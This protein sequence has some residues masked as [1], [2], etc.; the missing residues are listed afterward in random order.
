MPIYAN[1]INI[2]GTISGLPLYTNTLSAS[3]LSNITIQDDVRING[4]VY[5]N[6]RMDVGSTVF[7]TFRMSSNIPFSSGVNNILV[8]SSNSFVYDFTA[9]DMSAMSR[10]PLS[11]PTSNIYNYA[12]GYITVPVSGLYSLEMQGSFSNNPAKTDVKNGVYYKFLNHTHPNAR[13]A[14]VYTQ[15][16][17]VSTSHMAFLL[18]N[19][20]FQPTFYSNDP[21]AY[22]LGENGESF[23]SFT[24]AAT[25]TP[26]H[27]NYVRIPQ[28]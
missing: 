24:V 9:S 27:S 4:D 18:A 3:N 10:I 26:T 12:S 15:H 17:V 2:L 14:A 5:T 25:V 21:D 6:G 22:L 11:I 16:D 1:N 7:S 8:P 20:R 13:I 28:F 23:I 19:D